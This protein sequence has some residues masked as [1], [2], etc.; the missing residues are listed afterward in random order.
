LEKKSK[1]NELK[2]AITGNI[3]CGKSTF[4]KFISE[5]GYPVL[6]AD[7]I[8]KEI[9]ANDSEVRTQIMESFGVQSFHGKKVN[10]KFLADQV[11]SDPKK[12]KK[13]NSILHPRVQKKIEE[14]IK[15]FS[16]SSN[17]VF[18]EA[19]LIYEAKLE[20]IFN[21]ILIIT[22][23]QTIRMNRFIKARHL[24]EKDFFERENNQIK[25]ETKQKRADFVFTNNGSKSEL[26]LKAG[27]LIKVLKSS[28]AKK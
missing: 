13:I 5:L 7:D 24:T 15:E 26:K 4:S 9:L 27:L 6:Y 19:A 22:A 17:I 3:G 2:V 18:V 25:Q 8:S 10:H 23:D 21:F 12:L 1:S 20:K 28:Q 14:L 11:F 16:K